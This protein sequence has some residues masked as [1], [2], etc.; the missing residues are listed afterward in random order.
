V[1]NKFGWDYPP[2]ITGREPEI[3]GYQ[4][5][6]ENVSCDNDS[7]L[8]YPAHVVNEMLADYMTFAAKAIGNPLGIDVQGKHLKERWTALLDEHSGEFACDFEGEVDCAYTN[9]GLR[10]W[11]CPRCGVEHE[12]DM[13]ADWEEQEAE[14]RADRELEE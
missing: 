14:R 9:E 13:R 7:A 3:A 6:T 4:E 5:G 1:S 8:W 11:T 10:L 2:G 12:D